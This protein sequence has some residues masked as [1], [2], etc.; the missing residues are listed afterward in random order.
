[1]SEPLIVLTQA[2]YRSDDSWLVRGVDLTLQ[3][4]EIL[5][6]IGPNGSGKSTTA[7][8]AL[9][10][11]PTH[12]GSAARPTGLSVGYVPQKLHID[13]TVPLRVERFM[14]LTS[15]VSHSV[16]LEA[17]RRTG[18]QHLL[19]AE[20][21]LLSGGEFQRVQLARAIAREPDLL[22]LD[23]PVQGVDFNGEIALYE[24]ISDIRTELGC[25]VLM[26]SHDLHVVMA[27]TDKVVCLNGHVCCSGAPVQVAQSEE[28][29]ALFG[30]RSATALALY[31]HHHDHT[32][33]PDGSVSHGHNHDG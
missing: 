30:L 1:M 8:L 11:L 9:G 28:Y 32:H 7:K 25:G 5:T 13:W 31:E 17:L 12:E 10:I 14:R 16:M 4:G 2:G 19:Q 6:L 23:E 27:A 24:L 20:L 26:I 18:V 29:K 22:V 15:S 33:L 3:R 21:R